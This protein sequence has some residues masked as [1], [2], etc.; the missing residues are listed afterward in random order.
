MDTIKTWETDSISEVFTE[1]S[2]T[3]ENPPKP[4]EIFVMGMVGVVIFAVLYV[5]ITKITFVVVR[6]RKRNNSE[7][8]EHE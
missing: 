1:Q 2:Q 8:Y 3:T 6:S 7:N 5:L 4:L